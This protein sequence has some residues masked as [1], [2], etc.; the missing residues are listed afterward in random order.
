MSRRWEAGM[1]GERY[2][3]DKRSKVVH[4]LDHETEDCQ[5]DEI[6]RTTAEVAFRILEDAHAQGYTDHEC[7]KKAEEEKQGDACKAP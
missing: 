6:I 4:D 1:A 7:V 5:V 3:G 2:I